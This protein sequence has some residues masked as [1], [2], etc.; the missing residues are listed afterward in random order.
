MRENRDA[1]G[2]EGGVVWEGVSP[3]PL[4]VGSGEGAVP[5]SQKIFGFLISKW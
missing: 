5:P 4:E 2:A 1:E 3:S